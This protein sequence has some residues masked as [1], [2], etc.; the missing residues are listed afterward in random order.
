MTSKEE[1]KA[2][3]R[4]F[5]VETGLKLSWRGESV[6]IEVSGD[7]QAEDEPFEQKQET[8]RFCSEEIGAFCAKEVSRFC[9]TSSDVYR[10]ERATMKLVLGVR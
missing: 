7:E 3:L 4:H 5:E 6:A 10:G 1:R 2:F 9:R 8:G